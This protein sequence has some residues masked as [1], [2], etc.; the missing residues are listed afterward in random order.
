MYGNENDSKTEKA[1]LMPLQLP[2]PLQQLEESKVNEIQ[3]FMN[4]IKSKQLA[5]RLMQNTSSL[6]SFSS[7][8]SYEESAQH[9][10]APPQKGENFFHY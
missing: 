10:I 7:T 9:K 2:L 6:S 8:T 3:E 1:S 5:K 4:I